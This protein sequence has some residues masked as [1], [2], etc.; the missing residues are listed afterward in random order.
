MDLTW[1]DLPIRRANNVLSRERKATMAAR[2]AKPKT[3][4]PQLDSKRPF[5][6]AKGDDGGPSCQA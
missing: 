3:T 4:T 2:L 5:A 1:F 6:G